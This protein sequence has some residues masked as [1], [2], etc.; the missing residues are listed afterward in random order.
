MSKLY[1]L[2]IESSSR[3]KNYIS[4][5]RNIATFAVIVLHVTAPFV[6]QFNKI[7]FASWQL[8]NLLDSMLRFSVPVFVMISGAVLLDRNE[9]L[10]SFLSKRLKRIFIPFLF[11]SIVYF[12]FEYG[13]HFQ[14]ISILNLFQLLINKLSKGS[15]Y[16]LWYVYMILGVYLF[17]PIIRKWAQNSTKQELQY[18]L[19]L[20]IITLFI[21]TDVAEYI[22]SI[23]VLYF[24][25]YLGYLVLGHYLD[26][27][28]ATK[29]TSNAI[30]LLFF[31]L[32]VALT[33]VSTNYLSV[34]ENKLNTTYYNYLSPNVCLM[35]IGIFL[36]G[37]SCFKTTNS[38]LI[39]LD[40]Y[41]YGIYLIHVLVLHYVYQ[42][43]SPVTINTNSPTALLVFI[44]G[45]SIVTYIISYL[46]IRILAASS[47]IRSIV[48]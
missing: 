48:T 2:S 36:L 47:K 45:T 25:K 38:I 41:S 23:E 30:Y 28:V 14:T 43:I 32:G 40:K 42:I 9:P 44:I 29:K 13:S 4:N 24:S 8:A 37:K 18:F 35:A 11:W 15:Y 6:L 17:I 10:N 3:L 12:I 7:S 20:W 39:S 19:L 1:L 5:L 16:H 26:K 22:P 21:N 46:L 33:L 34:T 31:A 27:Y